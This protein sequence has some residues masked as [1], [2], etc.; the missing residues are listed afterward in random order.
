MLGVFAQAASE[1]I[2]ADAIELSDAGWFDRP[3]VK[4]AL[5]RSSNKESPVL[6][7]Y[8]GGSGT[9]HACMH[10]ATAVQFYGTLYICS[11]YYWCA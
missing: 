2:T 6:Q 7:A 1:Y 5:A 3:T 4:A 11:H 8:D 10:A 9:L